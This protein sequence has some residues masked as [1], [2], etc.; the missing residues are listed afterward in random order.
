M[1]IGKIVLR[2][3]LLVL[4]CLAGAGVY[5]Y[6]QAC[7]SPEGYQP[8]KLPPD[9]AQ[10]AANAF[11]NR[12]IIEEFGNQTQLNRPFDW[13]LTQQQ[14]NEALASMDEIAFQLGGSPDAVKRQ[15]EKQGLAGPAV[16]FKDD[17]V[18]LMVNSTT[19]DK[20]ISL[21]MSVSSLP[22]G[23]LATR[24]EDVRVGRQSVPRSLVDEEL[25]A[26]ENS[27][28]PATQN[29]EEEGSVIGPVGLVHAKDLGKLLKAVFGAINGE[30]IRPVLKWPVNHKK[31]AVQSVDLYNGQMTLHLKPIVPN[32]SSAASEPAEP[33]GGFPFLH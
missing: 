15:M 16:Q 1:R 28:A 30:P 23:R 17:R 21:E 7:S 14:A 26:V 4:L 9:Q 6:H 22:D 32:P 8:L 19:Y 3:L 10:A 11:I 31:V 2:L 33:P 27:L 18:V 12:K 13:T 24:L 29:A 5:V 25:A 20:V